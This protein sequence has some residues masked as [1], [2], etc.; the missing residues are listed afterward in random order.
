[1]IVN[2]R[3]RDYLDSLC[4]GNS[5]IME[6]MRS[7]AERDRIPVIRRE[8]EELL[9]TLV[10]LRRPGSILE[11][12]TASGYSAAVMALAAGPRVR[13]DT[14]ELGRQ[15]HELALANISA[16]GLEDRV[17]CILADAGQ[18]LRDCREKYDMV[19]LDAA[20]A[21]YVRW[22]PDIL[23]V[24][25]EGA[26]LAADNV[27]LD[28]SVAESRFALGRRDRTVHERMREFL[29]EITHSGALRSCVLPVGDGVSLSVLREKEE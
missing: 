18:Y 6:E 15:D 3:I 2:E 13:I 17:S 14:V 24:M 1:M 27:L 4:P 25:R 19:F 10:A 21:Q 8:T 12:G 20:K 26:L 23:G 7:R 28:G 5:A 16:L 9:K 11:L 29:F 22:L